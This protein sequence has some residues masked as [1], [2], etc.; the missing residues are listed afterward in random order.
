MIPSLLSCTIM[1]QISKKY[2]LAFIFFI[3]TLLIAIKPLFNKDLISGHDI[4]PHAIWVQLFYNAIKE[5]QFPVRWINGILPGLSYPQFQFYPPLLYYLTSLFQFF[6]ANYIT[7]IYILIA[8]SVGLGWLGMY[9]LGRKHFG[10]Y[11][12]IASATLFVFT[13]YRFSQLYVRGAFGE[14]LATSLIPFVFLFS[15]KPILFAIFLTLVLLAHQP[16][17]LI[18]S[19]PV[20]IWVVYHWLKTK[21][22]KIITNSLISGIIF[23]GLTSFFILPAIFERK[24][25]HWQNLIS[26]YYDFHQ[27]F[28]T[29]LQLL[30]SKWS[31]GISQAGPKDSMSFQIGIINLLVIIATIATSIRLKLQ[32]KIS[33]LIFLF[34]FAFAFFMSTNL[35]LPIWERFQILQFSQYPWRFLLLIAFSTSFLVGYV[36]QF[37]DKFS[38]NTRLAILC[39]FGITAMIFNLN[40]I[41]PGTYIPRDTFKLGSQT[42]QAASSNDLTF[43]LEPGYLPIF[44]NVVSPKR[45]ETAAALIS[46]EAEINIVKNNIVDKKIVVDARTESTIH[47]F[48]NFFPGWTV[49]TNNRTRVPY[50]L[51]EDEGFMDVKLPAGRHELSLKLE[52]TPVREISEAITLLTLLILIGLTTKKKINHS[53]I[54]TW[55]NLK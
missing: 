3:L 39:G 7:A 5:G 2:S 46:G 53:T 48:T 24:F 49:R 47:L 1:T 31:Y 38:K 37:T 19:L 54:D 16:T 30:Y 9:L 42:L 8:I 41:K 14:H 20:L 27:H 35:S 22:N 4:A 32:S 11:G 36:F 50:T 44:T 12:G 25:I 34:F 18:I 13:P 6:G 17:F 51:T 40:F 43:S 10:E 52:K 45:P 15:D 23:L 33:L 26:D 28:A 55:F 21:D 29:P